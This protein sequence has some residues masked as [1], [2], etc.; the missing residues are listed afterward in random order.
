M[1]KL[2]ARQCKLQFKTPAETLSER[3]F[4]SSILSQFR[5]KKQSSKSKKLGA[6]FELKLNTNESSKSHFE[7]VLIITGYLKLFEKLR[8]QKLVE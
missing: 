7:L 6:F 8:L 2:N 1:N 3:S 4:Y 5:N